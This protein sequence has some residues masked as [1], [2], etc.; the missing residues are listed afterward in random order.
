MSAAFPPRAT[1]RP[2]EAAADVVPL[3]EQ[4]FIGPAPL[5]HGEDPAAYQAL[6]AR[7]SAAVQRRPRADRLLAAVGSLHK[8]TYAAGVFGAA[9]LRS[10][11]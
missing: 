1:L 3:G 5:I 7:V 11:G 9:P 8:L 10:R 2:T 4:D 6:L